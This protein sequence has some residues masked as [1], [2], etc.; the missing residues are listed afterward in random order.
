MGDARHFMRRRWLPLCSS[1]AATMQPVVRNRKHLTPAPGLPD[2]GTHAL[3][4]GGARRG[5][6]ER[7]ILRRDELSYEGWAL[8]SAVAG[9]DSF[10]R[11]RCPSATS[12]RSRLGTSSRLPWF[13]ALAWFG[14]KRRGTVRSLALSSRCSRRVSVPFRLCLSS[15]RPRPRRTDVVRTRPSWR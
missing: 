4:R 15:N 11:N 10:S 8:T 12:S 1:E 2:V 6:T 9:S 5:V 3:R 13:D 14:S 7:V